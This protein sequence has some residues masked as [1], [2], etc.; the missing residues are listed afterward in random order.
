MRWVLRIVGVLVLIVV[1]AVAALFLMPTDRIAALVETRFEAATGR[2][3]SVEGD[4]RPSLWP[5]LGVRTGAI[6]ISN[7]DWAS[8]TPMLRAD[9]LAVAV[10]F[11][12]LIGGDIRVTGIEVL[13]PQILLETNADGTGN[14]EM[15]GSASETTATATS[16]ED[17]GGIPAFSIDR[18]VISDASLT[19]RDA[20]G[21]ETRLT[22]LDAELTLPD[23]DGPANLTATGA[24]NGA[25]L[26][27]TA[28][29]PVFSGMLGAGSDGIA[30]NI[31]LGDASLHF[32]G[33]AGLAP[34]RVTGELG[35]TLGMLEGVATAAGIARPELPEG[36]GRNSIAFSGAVDATDTRVA[37]AGAEFLLD[38]NTLRGDVAIA[39]DGP[40][41]KVTASLAT[42]ALDLSALG[43][44]DDG[45]QSGAG[46][47][48]AQKGWSTDPID[49]SGLNAIDAEVSLA[50]NSVALGNSTLGRT[51]LYVT[52][53]RGRMV[54]EIRELV[55]YDGAVAGSFVVN[56]RD[57]LSVRADLAGSSLAIS[58]LLAELLDYDQLV[59]IGDMELSVLGSGGN[60]NAIMNS[61]NGD[62]SFRFGAGELL[63]LD[64]VGMLRN[65]DTS[66]VGQG[67]KTIFD[68]ITGTF[69]IVNGVV[70]N[71]N[72]SVLAPLLTAT[73][74]GEIGLGGQT[75]NY[76]LTPKLL[77]GEGEGISVPLLIT[78]TWDAPRFRL[79]M[80]ALVND[81]VKA[82]IEAAK[83]R[84]E[85]ELKDKVSERLGVAGGQNNAREDAKDKIEDELKKGLRN[86]FDR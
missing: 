60:L 77:A 69:R 44:E 10:D 28:N 1:V 8:D 54:T 4:V 35:G 59:S 67:S 42:G 56:A 18:A 53:D 47:E 86:L 43:G 84:A 74:R 26:D 14:W 22:A 36:L 13:T 30:L 19:Y 62:G 33:R 65:L 76:R 83:D 38:Q 6:E 24:L 64:L 52:I 17:T 2:T 39:L 80:D 11:G 55:A 58:R 68:E 48:T 79:D 45:G 27:V 70:I 66:F 21:A 75:L 5:A 37:F 25:P 31:D 81:K 16:P 85:Q 72:L 82:E 50:A 49:A 23:F 46:Q 51:N 32:D 61:L 34:L 41:P 73:G 29:I 20:A 15:S 3:L 63:G 12:A 57:G 78:G 9:G 7:A 71:E 40:R